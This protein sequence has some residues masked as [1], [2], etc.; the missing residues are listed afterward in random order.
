M[1]RTMEQKMMAAS[2]VSLR[3]RAG[4]E[5]RSDW[6]RIAEGRTKR[7]VKRDWTTADCGMSNG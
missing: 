5:I 4:C 3:I 2:D 7:C 6:S 1:G